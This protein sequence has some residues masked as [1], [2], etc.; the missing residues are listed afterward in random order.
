[1]HFGK[2]RGTRRIQRVPLAVSA[3]AELHLAVPH[4][5]RSVALELLQERRRYGLRIAH[6]PHGHQV[7][8]EGRVSARPHGPLQPRK[9]ERREFLGPLER[10]VQG[11][12][13][14]AARALG[15][16]DLARAR[17]HVA[18]AQVKQR[19]DEARAA[20]GRELVEVASADDE[21][22]AE[23]GLAM[24]E[25]PEPHVDVMEERRA[26]Q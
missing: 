8:C 23:L 16:G 2:P 6:V 3:D 15:F 12:A 5:R 1:M 13:E 19:L 17:E 20:H 25:C 22:P 9:P 18:A 14:R 7:R 21:K 26:D 4:D 24:Q 11:V 10:G